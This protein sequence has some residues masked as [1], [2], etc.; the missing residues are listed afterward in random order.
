LL[1]E[2]LF[3]CSTANL[4]P[5]WTVQCY[6][7]LF[8]RILEG[9]ECFFSRSASDT[10][11]T[12]SLKEPLFNYVF[13]RVPWVQAHLWPAWDFASDH[14]LSLF[15]R[16]L[17]RVSTL[18]NVPFEM[19]DA[20]WDFHRE[21]GPGGRT[22]KVLRSGSSCRENAPSGVAD[23]P[24][25]EVPSSPSGCL[26]PP[27]TSSGLGT[28]L[29]IA[30]K[31]LRE[32]CGLDL[33]ALH[34]R[35][36]EAAF[37][38]I[39]SGSVQEPGSF[40]SRRAGANVPRF[41]DPEGPSSPYWI[42]G[43]APPE[44]VALLPW[45]LFQA[46]LLYALLS[47]CDAQVIL[48]EESIAELSRVLEAVDI[49]PC[50]LLYLASVLQQREHHPDQQ[51][52]SGAQR[53]E[54]VPMPLG[55]LS[56][57]LTRLFV[58]SILNAASSPSPE[59]VAVLK[60]HLTYMLLQERPGEVPD[61]RFERSRGLPD[62][63]V[64]HEVYSSMLAVSCGIAPTSL[65]CAIKERARMLLPCEQV[66][67]G[68]GPG[69][70]QP[71]PSLKA[72]NDGI[73]QKLP[74]LRRR[75]EASLQR[76][77]LTAV[78]TTIMGLIEELR[79]T[80]PELPGIDSAVRAVLQIR[81]R[82]ESPGNLVYRPAHVETAVAAFSV[83]LA[84][85][86]R[87]YY[88]S[89]LHEREEF[90]RD[91]ITKQ[92][93][94]RAG[95]SAIVP[96]SEARNGPEYQFKDL[97]PPAPLPA[98]L[99]AVVDR[100]VAE[101]VDAMDLQ[102]HGSGSSVID[103]SDT[104]E[105]PSSEK[106]HHAKAGGDVPASLAASTQNAL[107]GESGSLPSQK[108]QPADG[109][110]EWWG[111][112][113]SPSTRLQ[114]SADYTSCDTSA[115]SW[116][117]LHNPSS[118][119]DGNAHRLWRLV[120]AT[121]EL[122]CRCL[123]MELYPSGLQHSQILSDGLC[124]EL[125]SGSV[126]G[127]SG[128]VV[129]QPPTVLQQVESYFLACLDALEARTSACTLASCQ[130]RRLSYATSLGRFMLSHVSTI[131]VQMQT[132]DF[133]FPARIHVYSID[134]YVSTNSYLSSLAYSYCET[135][136]SII[137]SCAAGQNLRSRD[138]RVS[139][140]LA[141][142][143]LGLWRVA[144]C[145]CYCTIAVHIPLHAHL[146]Y[147]LLD[148][149]AALNPKPSSYISD[150]H[151]LEVLPSS[152]FTTL[153]S[154]T[155]YLPN[156]QE[157]VSLLDQAMECSGIVARLSLTMAC[158]CGLFRYD[159]QASGFKVNTHTAALDR[160][161]AAILSARSKLALELSRGLATEHSR[162]LDTP[163]THE[164]PFQSCRFAEAVQLAAWAP[165]LLLLTH[166][167]THGIHDAPEGEGSTANSLALRSQWSWSPP[168]LPAAI[169]DYVNA[170]PASALN[171]LTDVFHLDYIFSQVLPRGARRTF[172]DP[173]LS[174][175]TQPIDIQGSTLLSP[176]CM[177]AVLRFFGTQK[178]GSPTASGQ[179]PPAKGFH[180]QEITCS[181]GHAVVLACSYAPVE[182]RDLR[183]AVLSSWATRI[184]SRQI[185]S[186]LTS[187]NCF[188]DLFFR[189]RQREHALAQTP[190]LRTTSESVCSDGQVTFTT[191]FAYRKGVLTR[192]S[193]DPYVLE[194]SAVGSQQTQTG[195]PGTAV[196]GSPLAKA[197][198]IVD[199]IAFWVVVLEVFLCRFRRM[200][201]SFEALGGQSSGIL[202]G[203]SAAEI[204]QAEVDSFSPAA[205]QIPTVASDMQQRK[206][207]GPR[208][209]AL[210]RIS[211]S[212]YEASRASARD[213]AP[214][215]LGDARA[216][217]G[218]AGTFASSTNRCFISLSPP[219]TEYFAWYIYEHPQTTRPETPLSPG[220]QPLSR[221][222][223]EDSDLVLVCHRLEL[224]AQLS[225]A[226]QDAVT[227]AVSLGHLP[228][229]ICN[230]DAITPAMQWLL[231]RKVE[232]MREAF[233]DCRGEV[234]STL[235]QYYI[236][237]KQPQLLFDEWAVIHAQIQCVAD[238]LS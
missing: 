151:V 14:P 186:Y 120:S 225:L 135:L 141:E 139:E 235:T 231:L 19:G 57:Y 118:S 125:P 152:L 233:S 163:L 35:M 65:L 122:L 144:L 130:L 114:P 71:A 123:G 194:H 34:S 193:G 195:S 10:A 56:E 96:P 221:P 3:Q 215:D 84:G 38:S 220:P 21:F 99:K 88:S 43:V 53:D 1:L 111:T 171:N 170:I 180:E 208:G 222:I 104:P 72:R 147:G 189:I 15:A 81:A 98:R 110:G 28:L 64:L 159:L 204:T 16:A 140:R 128:A 131:A 237:L 92:D 205:R 124:R 169:Q 165:G 68:S 179:R 172:K 115:I 36:C 90:E 75:Q 23:A 80:F 31:R 232:A 226:S 142:G 217:R 59:L 54:E 201:S 22:E 70:D 89:L 63:S 85:L 209:V 132:L 227:R 119:R 161:S 166:S 238:Y 216:I 153:S 212:L 91:E 47:L 83:L 156:C 211:H 146:M 93:G 9:L 44:L 134:Y 5:E 7:L 223:T 160:A 150:P 173:I 58:H 188:Y 218:P 129:V 143:F 157:S 183:P 78:T 20:C 40:S 25:A 6:E 112:T 187:G 214:G 103:I 219:E 149:R 207:G 12:F 73:A 185:V 210:S 158:F 2:F 39:S 66:V 184:R 168:D 26:G 33:P 136:E 29:E 77:Q 192:V 27:G 234:I 137:R 236:A 106:A 97:P 69:N 102:P 108:I 126:R 105:T 203:G 213:P 55:Q 107:E 13:S 200:F 199:N 109:D 162:R 177:A 87:E 17:H 229:I 206:A 79:L 167:G 175:K 191:R 178:P 148:R 11:A 182:D 41:T 18:A 100:A 45:E 181:S 95:N 37:F 67:L 50:L 32:V 30:F 42:K 60:C 228:R 164:P 117:S 176:C 174:G 190:I 133:S 121:T 154:V 155:Q 197:S 202:A 82:A 8:P 198:S 49:S 196:S 224:V 138:R 61:S 116:H 113:V 145:L 24:G 4:D 101:P 94:E 74:L 51:A 127:R 230:L 62:R 46:Y 48:G 76:E 52:G 86:S